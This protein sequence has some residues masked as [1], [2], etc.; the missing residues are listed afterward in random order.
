MHLCWGVACL[1]VLAG[2]RRSG[3]RV[4]VVSWVSGVGLECVWRR[5][6]AR[7]CRCLLTDTCF[8]QLLAFSADGRGRGPSNK[9]TCPHVLR[10]ELSVWQYKAACITSGALLRVC[11]APPYGAAPSC[12]TCHPPVVGHHTLYQMLWGASAPRERLVGAGGCE[13]CAA[14]AAAK[15]ARTHEQATCI[16]GVCSPGCSLHKR[17]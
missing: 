13:S 2:F 10:T 14:G 15:A 5:R 17:A 11:T 6:P 3:G 16:C 7:E 12:E 4:L 9:V 8:G 1:H